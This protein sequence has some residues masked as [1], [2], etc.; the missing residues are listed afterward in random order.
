M[1]QDLTKPEWLNLHLISLPEEPVGFVYKITR[2]ADGKFYIGKKL[3]RSKVTKKP[4]KGK[5][6]KRHSTKESDWKTYWGSS[7][8]LVADIEK[9]GTEAFKR[10]IIYPCDSKF[11]LAYSELLTQ[12]NYNVMNPHTLTY[13]GIINVRLR[14]PRWTPNDVKKIITDLEKENGPVIKW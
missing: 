1:N 3:L 4:L 13:N 11:D 6:F 9:Y 8:E 12:I 10:E 2:I 14:R 7:K 5:R